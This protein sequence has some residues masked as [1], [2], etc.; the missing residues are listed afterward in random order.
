MPQLVGSRCALCQGTIGSIAEGEFCPTC[1][2]ACHF[3]CRNPQDAS[4]DS[5]R[6][7]ACGGDNSAMIAARVEQ[8]RFA[9]AAKERASSLRIYTAIGCLEVIAALL[10][11]TAIWVF[12]AG[13]DSDWD[14]VMYLGKIFLGLLVFIQAVAF[15]LIK[16][17]SWARWTGIALLAASLP[18][19]A[20][21]AA[22]LGLM[23]LGNGRH[24]AEY[25]A[26]RGA[27]KA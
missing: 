26:S 20:L 14:L 27:A 4:P 19:L 23:M 24:W 25:V 6:C 2:G 7:G 16:G 12:R 13:R 1:G 17:Q 10:L 22:A 8:E 5:S 3:N 15:G 9:I 21:P 18:S 11:L